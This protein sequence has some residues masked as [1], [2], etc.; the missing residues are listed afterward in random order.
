MANVFSAD[1]T[2]V[3]LKFGNNSSTIILFR[4]FFSHKEL[5]TMFSIK[6]NFNCIKEESLFTFIVASEALYDHSI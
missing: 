6:R 2:F 5:T 4:T 1:F 3:I